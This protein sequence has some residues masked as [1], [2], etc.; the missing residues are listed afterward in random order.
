MKKILFITLLSASLFFGLLSCTKNSDQKETFFSQ[1]E[2]L[3]KKAENNTV[4]ENISEY[5]KDFE[6]LLNQ[7]EKI[8][9]TKNWTPDD[10]EK[11]EDLIRRFTIST[12]PM[13]SFDSD[14][15][16][17]DFS[18][19]LGLDSDLNF[20]EESDLEIDDS[21]PPDFPNDFTEDFSG[22][23]NTGNIFGDL[24]IPQTPADD[25]LGLSGLEMPSFDF[26]LEE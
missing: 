25:D 5:Q 19:D 6:N 20:G 4:E 11:M 7:F 13:T 12:T 21:I 18:D 22:D 9:N 23:L 1:L 26:D 8:T 3:V 14:F 2:T 10:T 15:L 24:S 17:D 16:T